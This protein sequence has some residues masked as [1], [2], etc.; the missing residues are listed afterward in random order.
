VHIGYTFKGTGKEDGFM[1]IEFTCP[2][3]KQSLKASDEVAGK[4]GNCPKCGKEIKV[5]E[6]TAPEEPDK[7]K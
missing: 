7:E 2:H 5:P 1:T 6:K 4:T 3:C